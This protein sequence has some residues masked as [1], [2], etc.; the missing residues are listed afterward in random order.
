MTRSTEYSHL[1]SMSHHRDILIGLTVKKHRDLGVFDQV[2]DLFILSWQQEFRNCYR[3]FVYKPQGRSSVTATPWI[4]SWQ[5][6]ITVTKGEK[7]HCNTIKN[8]YLW[9]HSKHL[10]CCWDG[11]WIHFT[12]HL[13]VVCESSLGQLPDFTPVSL[14]SENDHTTVYLCLV[15]K[16]LPHLKAVLDGEQSTIAHSLLSR[17]RP[18]VGYV[19]RLR[20]NTEKTACLSKSKWPQEC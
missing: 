10:S 14:W 17:R 4:T 11:S 5:T 18:N 15:Q 13:G 20:S 2:F 12:Y 6:I 1:W 7:N 8:G 16:N 19:C 3:P 9:I